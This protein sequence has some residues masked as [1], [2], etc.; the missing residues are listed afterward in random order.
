MKKII[1]ENGKVQLNESVK[2]APSPS[3]VV[4]MVDGMVDQK[5]AIKFQDFIESF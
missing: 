1:V 5:L 2:I 3:G 4:N